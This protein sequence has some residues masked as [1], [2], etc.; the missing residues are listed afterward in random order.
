MLDAVLA[1]DGHGALGAQ[2]ARQQRL[3]DAAGLVQRLRVAHANPVAGAAVGQPFAPGDEGAIGVNVGP[4]LQP[5]GHA[6]AVGLERR[7]RLQVARARRAV[8]QGGA[9]DAEGQRAVANG[10][11][12]GLGGGHPLLTLAPRP[13]RKS[14]TRS[15]A[16]GAACTMP[17]MSASV[18][19]PWSAACS[20]MRGSACMSA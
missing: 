4:V 16:S 12:S 13:S 7:L 8:A 10:G 19:K 14:R 6:L 5:V 17:E 11:V 1:Q 15:L 18:K 9:R 3:P 2:A 20:A